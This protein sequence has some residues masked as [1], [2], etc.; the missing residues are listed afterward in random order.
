MKSQFELAL[1]YYIRYVIQFPSLFRPDGSPHI[2]LF[3][4]RRSGST[5]LR[6]MI[7]SQPNF[8][9]IDEPLNF[10]QN[11]YNPYRKLFPGDQ[12][13]QIVSLD[14]QKEK[15]LKNY[16]EG[17]LDRKYITR[18][19][20][21]AF[22]KNYHWL[23]KRYVVKE[24]NAKNLI[25]WFENYFG[26]RIKIIYH[27]RNPFAVAAS[28][29]ERGWSHYFNVYLEDAEYSDKYITPQ[30]RSMAAKI[31]HCGSD[32]EKYILD[33]CFENYVPLKLY[34]QRTWITISYESIVSDPASVSKKLCSVLD[35]PNADTMMNIVAKPSPTP[36]SRHSRSKIK[37]NG[38]ESRLASWQQKF[39]PDVINDF[40]K[41]L[42]AFE[43]D[44]YSSKSAYPKVGFDEQ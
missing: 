23:W 29:V 11:Q 30:I 19:Q 15:T 38:P 31:N 12:H 16:I 34:R 26:E 7:A 14:D 33:W 37:S 4:S 2:F 28:L 39:D 9:Y 27:I 5:L 3:S 10:A 22:D 1:R 44:L 18:S 6:D 40:S 20:W 25:P 43:I 41:I 24:L 36:L 21:R 17:I 42:D 32:A 13:G 8:N 35:L